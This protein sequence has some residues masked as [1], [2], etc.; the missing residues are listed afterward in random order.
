MTTEIDIRK[1][2]LIS[3]SV[4]K[5]GSS[6][7]YSYQREMFINLLQGPAQA[8]TLFSMG[9]VH[10][11][12]FLGLKKNLHVFEAIADPSFDQG[13]LI[14][15]MHIPVAGELL[16]CMNA[17]PNVFMSFI[18]RDPH[19]ILMSA[20]DNHKRTGEFGQFDTLERGIAQINGR[21]REIYESVTAYNASQE[22]PGRII[23]VQRYS[24]L[25]EHPSTS[26]LDSFPPRLKE[27]LV[28]RLLAKV[29]RPKTVE[30]KSAHRRT[31]AAKSRDLSA[32]SEEEQIMIRDGLSE[33]RTLFGYKKTDK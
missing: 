13:P 4:P 28:S 20:M 18:V 21:F 24:T 5:S 11:G 12:G 22:D 16:T 10:A 3:N 1:L 29:A 27:F 2:V 17:N 9:A 19:E 26:V 23:P 15:K 33:T 32:F 6:F 8:D 30:K 31:G 25:L 14:I 7:L